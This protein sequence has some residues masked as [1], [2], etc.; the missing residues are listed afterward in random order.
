MIL[1]LV[2]RNWKL[3]KADSAPIPVEPIPPA[4]AALEP[5]PPP[6]PLALAKELVENKQYE[7]FYREITRVLY[8][9]IGTKLDIPGSELN[10]NNIQDVLFVRGWTQEM[11]DQLIGVLY[12]CEVRLYTPGQQELDVLTVLERADKI[13]LQIE[14]S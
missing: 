2:F 10:K 6:E 14:K 5:P 3:R 11:F 12:D 1:Y 13:L 8:Q 7:D 9:E 4:T